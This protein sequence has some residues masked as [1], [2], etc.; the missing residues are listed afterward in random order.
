MYAKYEKNIILIPFKKKNKFS[1]LNGI[2]FKKKL[3]ELINTDEIDP[4]TIEFGY[5]TT[6]ISL[7][8]INE[9]K[10]RKIPTVF[11]DQHPELMLLNFDYFSRHALKNIKSMY[12][13]LSLKMY[14]AAL[15][16]SDILLSLSE[17]AS[18]IQMKVINRKGSVVEPATDHFYKKIKYNPKFEKR[19]N[20]IVS[21]G[22]ITSQKRFDKV[23][24]IFS[25]AIKNK[26]I[27]D[28]SKLIIIGTGE[29][30]EVKKL[31]R[32]ANKLGIDENI[33]FTGKLNGDEIIEYLLKTKVFIL[34][35]D[36]ESFGLVVREAMSAGVPVITSG[37]TALKEANVNNITGF[38]AGS[39]TTAVKYLNLLMKNKT[40]WN[41]ISAFNYKFVRDY[42][43]R[44]RAKRIIKIVK[45]QIET[46]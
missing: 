7:P 15:K 46:K 26:K 12:D 2:A 24:Y 13:Y 3:N 33:H 32:L 40:L 9:L 25:Y 39:I 8:L 45:S 38:N 44:D 18:K 37:K 42:T 6:Q 10:R 14:G 28:N 31:Q 22:R 34:M 41:R 21:I 30:D 29:K 4:S 27:P 35:S 1:I 11:D 23:L 36:Y 16:N 20:Y 5:F 17:Y 19:E 43:Y